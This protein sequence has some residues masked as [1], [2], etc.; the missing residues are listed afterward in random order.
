MRI[1]FSSV[2]V[3]V[4][5]IVLASSASALVSIE[6]FDDTGGA[7]VAVGQTFHVDIVASYDGTPSL[8]GIFT[9]VVWD[10]SELLLTGATDPPF[11]IFGGPLGSL[12]RVANPF[13]LPMDP[14]GSLRTVQ[15]GA[16]P[17]QEGNAGPPTLITTLTFQVLSPGDGVGQVD[18]V[19]LQGDIIFGGSDV[20]FAAL[21]PGDFSL[22][23]TS[24]ALVP[25]PTTGVL[26]GLG[27]L[28]LGMTRRRPN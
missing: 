4:F 9:S 21:A 19:L 26:L 20:G 3:S 24:V 6:H 8:A 12:Q 5:A 2:S 18:S 16:A 1:F 17:T 7:V 13:S 23:S 28:G 25:E 11:S 10:P 14:V 27:L 22:G 15:F